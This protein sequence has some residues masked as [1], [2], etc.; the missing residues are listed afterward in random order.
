MN[1]MT[2]IDKDDFPPSGSTGVSE[3]SDRHSVSPVLSNGTIEEESVWRETVRVMLYL[4]PGM[5]FEKVCD[6]ITFCRFLPAD[7]EAMFEEFP[8]GMNVLLHVS[9]YRWLY[10][11]ILLIVGCC[12]AVSRNQR[13]RS[14][15]KWRSAL[16]WVLVVVS[17]VVT[18]VMGRVCLRILEIIEPAPSV[19]VGSPFD[20]L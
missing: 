3:G 11:T 15:L 9:R 16:F 10:P 8:I 20:Q 19:G 17:V 14:P 13:R 1:L 2:N 4:L 5:A 7:A 12:T 6:A 18:Y